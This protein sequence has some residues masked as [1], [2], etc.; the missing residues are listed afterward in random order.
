[1]SVRATTNGGTG[2]T[3]SQTNFTKEGGNYTNYYYYYYYYYLLTE[4]GAVSNV[5]FQRISPTSVNVSWTPLTLEEAKGFITGYTVTLTPSTNDR[6]RQSPITMTAR[7]D[8]SYVVFNGLSA[9]ASYSISVSGSTAAGT[10]ETSSGPSIPTAV[11]PCKEEEWG[12]EKE[13]V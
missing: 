6:R 12:G 1:M 9:E 13:V 3:T 5:N 7:P 11:A 2:P 4:P 8:Q 10:G